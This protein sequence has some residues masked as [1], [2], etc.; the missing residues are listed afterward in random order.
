[1][2]TISRAILCVLLLANALP[3]LAAVGRIPASFNVGSSGTAEYVIPLWVPPGTNGMTPSLAL[4]YNH[5]GGNG[6]LGVGWALRGESEI[7]RCASTL[8]QDGAFREIRN[9]AGDRFCLDGMRLRLT[10]STPYGSAGSTYQTELETFSRTTAYGTAGAG[11]AYFVV[12]RKDGLIYEYGNSNDSRIESL[13]QATARTWA[14]NRMRDRSGNVIDFVYTEDTTNGDY[15]LSTVQYTSN[16]SQGLTAQYVVTFVYEAKPSNEIDVR[17]V[18]GSQISQIMQLDRVDVTYAGNLVRRYELTYEPTLS[19]AG[20]SRLASVSERAGSPL[21]STSDTTFSYQNGSAGLGA[22]V[23]TGVSFPTAVAPIPLDVNGDGRTDLAYSS[24]TGSGFWVVA[25]ANATGGYNTP[26]TTS[27][28]NAGYARAIPIDYNS[29]GLEDLLVPRTGNWWVMTGAAGGFNTPIDTQITALNTGA[30]NDGWAGDINGDGRDDL[31]TANLWGPQGGDSIFY[32]LRNPSGTFSAGTYMEAPLAANT[33]MDGP[34]VFG[35]SRQQYRHRTP[36]FNGDGSGDVIYKRLNL[37]QPQ[38]AAATLVVLYHAGTRVE[39]PTSATGTPAPYYFGDFNGDGNTDILEYVTSGG[40]AWIRFSTGTGFANRVIQ[41]AALPVLAYSVVLDWDGDG[42]D[43]LLGYAT[44]TSSWW[45]LRSNGESLEAAVNTGLSNAMPSSVAVVDIN[46]DGLDDLAYNLSG[47]W[48][49]RLHAGVEADLLRTATD[50]F[51]NS[52]TFNYQPLTANVYS[53]LSDASFPEQ[54]YQGPLYVVSSLDASN[55]VGGSYTKTFSY[56]GAR[57]HRQGRGFEGFWLTV[58]RDS[59]NTFYEH[60]YL[61]RTFP[62]TGTQ[63]RVERYESSS[64]TLISRTADTWAAHNYGSGFDTRALPYLSGSTTTRYEVGGAYNGALISTEVLTNVVNAATGTVTDTSVTTTEAT[65]GHGIQPGQSYT[66]RTYVPSLF[67]D[68]VNWC[69]GRPATT[70]EISSHTLSDGAQKTRVINTA[71]DGAKCRQTQSTT[72]PGDANWQITSDFGYDGFGNLNTHTLTGA[73][74]AARTTTTNWGTTGQFP[75][76]ITNAMSE[77]TLFGWNYALGLKSSETDPNGIVTQWQYDAFGD[78]TRETSPDGTYSVFAKAYCSAAAGT[79]Y[80]GDQTFYRANRYDYGSDN[81]QIKWESTFFDRFDRPTGDAHENPFGAQIDQRTLYDALGRVQST[82]TP[83]F[84]TGGT[85]YYTT[86]SYDVLNRPTQ[87]SR[88]ISATNSTAQT[89]T[90]AYEGMTT[91]AVDAEGKQS[92]MVSNVRG[93]TVQSTD[94]DSYAQNLFYDAFGNLVRVQDSAGNTLQSLSWNINGAATGLTDIDRGAT[95]YVPNALGERRSETDAN[96]RTTTFTYDALSRLLTRQ[97]PDGSATIT[98]TNTWGTSAAARNIGRLATTQ[99][100]GT[101]IL[102]NRRTFTYDTIGRLAQ[103]R[104]TEL[105]TNTTYDIDQTY[106]A[107][108]GFLSTLTYPQSTSTYRLRL[109]YEYQRGN[110]YRILDANAP[111]TVFWVANATNPFEQVT[112]ETF[113]NGMRTVRGYDLVTSRIKSIQSTG[114]GSTSI[115]NLGYDFDRVGN[116][117]ERRDLRQSLTEH[118]YYDNLHRL[119]YSTLNGATNL[120]MSYSAN[121]NITNK[122]GVGAYGYHP[123]KIHAVQTLGGTPSYQYDAKGDGTGQ[124]GEFTFNYYTSGTPKVANWVEEGYSSTFYPDPDDQRF[125]QVVA[126]PG[127]SDTITYIGGLLEKEV[128]L[129]ATTWRHYIFAPSGRIGVH[130]RSSTGTPAP[131]TYYF[132]SDHLGSIDS[133]T[134]SAGAVQVRLSYDAFGARRNEAGWSGAVPN[135]DWTQIYAISHRGFTDH[136]MLD[137]LDVTHMNG[138]FYDQDSGR[139]T[140][141]DPIVSESG[142]QSFNRY[143]YVGNNPLSFTDPTGYSSDPLA[144]VTVSATRLGDMGFFH[145][146]WPISRNTYWRVADPHFSESFDSEYLGTVTI[147]ARRQKL[148]VPQSTDRL[149]EGLGLGFVGCTLRQTRFIEPCTS[150]QYGDEL[151]NYAGNLTMAQKPTVMVINVARKA[152]QDV[153]KRKILEAIK[154]VNP[155]NDV[156]N[157]VRCAIATDRTLGGQPTSAKPGEMPDNLIQITY[158]KDF[159]PKSF[160]QIKDDLLKAGPGARGIVS[161]DVKDRPGVGHTFNAINVDGRI[162]FPDGQSRRFQTNLRQYENVEFIQTFPK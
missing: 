142:T 29:D 87:V 74:M 157:C 155:T 2:R 75:V 13:G 149:F 69:I 88:P 27:I 91:R 61:N 66:H 110:L 113:G 93:E 68:T 138:R 14:L 127:G 64:N 31:V 49:Y 26:I 7:T 79:C 158:G 50:G 133:I 72:Q 17:Y 111:T 11:P 36:D 39:I 104:Y 86:Y 95:T 6:V 103:T 154:D 47:T 12:E 44:S 57:V 16:A 107:T 58:T 117:T 9:D 123:T 148:R 43:D 45:L 143:S 98:Y 101:S 23:S 116:L 119:D 150:Q 139:F 59:R 80:Y 41:S 115:Q 144:E 8:A 135:A 147:S 96:G 46:G 128:A 151:L 125:R 161:A 134:N 120:D 146:Y 4:A 19:S 156:K 63:W 28:T 105:G 132:T 35:Q 85:P 18:A 118:F 121:G 89:T 124:P 76:S 106:S 73:N 90:T 3:A 22:Q 37:S 102:D 129:T 140:S 15:R 54:D 82:S 10:G 160:A 99:V 94:H 30:G 130:I 55:G 25:L 84:T 21:E 20:N 62:L 126:Y 141:G 137:D 108:T 71:W 92:V 52:V 56:T 38:P 65:S 1:M 97:E 131:T 81:V 145:D 122:T 48:Y 67:T 100:A 5:L 70:Q 83:Y 112:D 24:S 42:N 78:M 34:P 159:V 109:Q 51:G 60:D 32:N 33:A 152:A 162:Y 40:P 77:S 153:V 114:P 136:E 53:K